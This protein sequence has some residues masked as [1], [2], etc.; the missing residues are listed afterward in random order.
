M[1]FNFSADPFSQLDLFVKKAAERGLPEP[2]AM[3]LATLGSDLRP[4]V[5]IVLYKGQV[6]GGLSFYTNYEGRKARE[7][8]QNPAASVVF[9]WAPLDCQIRVEGRVE[10]LTRAESEAY[11]RSRPRQSQLGAWASQQSREVSDLNQIQQA[12]SEIENK[13]GES[14]IPCP[15]HWGGFHLIPDRFEFWFARLGRLHERYCFEKSLDAK[16]E[17]SWRRFHRFP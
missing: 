2:N 17:N 13:F 12:L 10:K 4:S 7:L 3:S 5:R 6:R 14:E 9:Y 8:L 16:N 11:F 15:P 1:E